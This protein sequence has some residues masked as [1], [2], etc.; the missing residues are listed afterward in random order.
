M[1]GAMTQENCDKIN[2]AVLI[3]FVTFGATTIR[4][5]G[6]STMYAVLTSV[7]HKVDALISAVW[8]MAD[9]CLIIDFMLSVHTFLLCY[10]FD[11]CRMAGEKIL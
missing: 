11:C 3:L 1:L 4:L 9:I 5:H 7:I 8:E 10:Q 6:H 2:G